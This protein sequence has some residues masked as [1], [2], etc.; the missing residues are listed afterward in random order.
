MP[1]AIPELFCWTKVGSLSGEGLAALVCRKELE[2]RAGGGVFYWGV[3]HAVGPAVAELAVDGRDPAVVFSRMRAATPERPEEPAPLTLWR[4]YRDRYGHQGALPGHVVVTSRA[5]A[6]GAV[7]LRSHYALICR[8]EQALSTVDQGTLRLHELVNY[9]TS[10]P[11]RYSN[12]TTLVK[13]RTAGAAPDGPEYSVLAVAS[14]L[15]PYFV[16]L[17]DPIVLPADS[18]RALAEAASRLDVEGWKAFAQGLRGQ[19]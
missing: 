14:L 6:G 13:R 18:S 11:L 15:Q 9:A 7:P 1:I 16:E 19:N 10:R 2:R 8:S 4:A 5:P 17:L 12:V 3:G